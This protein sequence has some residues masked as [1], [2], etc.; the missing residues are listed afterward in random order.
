MLYVGGMNELGNKYAEAS[1]KQ[2][3]A[4][5]AGEIAA[6]K[7]QLEWKTDQ[8]VHLDETIRYLDSSAEPDKIPP[9]RPHKRFKLFKQGELARTVLDILRRAGEPISSKDVIAGVAAKFG[10]EDADALIAMRPR[11]R[12]SLHYLENIRGEIEKVGKGRSAT[13]TLAESFDESSSD[14]EDHVRN[15]RS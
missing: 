2:A 4:S 10:H 13:W 6:L 12:S 8:L 9:K 3:R 1:L 14:H 15:H 11:I 7:K 5:L